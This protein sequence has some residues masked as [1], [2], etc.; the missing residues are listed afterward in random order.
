[1][2]LL[3]S[4]LHWGINT[5]GKDI[6][7]ERGLYTNEGWLE[8]GLWAT[9]TFIANSDDLPIRQFIALFQGGGRSCSCHLI[10]E[11]QSH[12]AQLLLDVA[13]NL[14]LSCHREKQGFRRL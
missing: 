7:G 5:E 9:E 12:I 10:L 6:F 13:H 2:H 4:P 8:E 11:V 14:T 3:I 1:M